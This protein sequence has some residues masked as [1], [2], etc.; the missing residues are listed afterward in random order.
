MKKPCYLIFATVALVGI[1]I[2][3]AQSEA[4]KGGVQID[5]GWRTNVLPTIKTGEDFSNDLLPTPGRC[6]SIWFVMPAGLAGAWRSE[7][8]ES[9]DTKIT[10][11]SFENEV[12]LG[13]EIDKNGTIW[14]CVKSPSVSEAKIEKG[15]TFRVSY[16]LSEMRLWPEKDPIQTTSDNI[17][18]TV[19]DGKIKQIR[20]FE[21]TS[22][23][24]LDRAGRMIV[25]ENPTDTERI[26]NTSY[27][28]ES[29]FLQDPDLEDDFKTWLK[30]TGRA[31]L[32]PKN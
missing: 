30:D 15:V 9:W 14:H 25:S 29:P 6:R 19:L 11:R 12:N 23:L 5:D 7:K 26:E 32:L 17:Q 21:S 16:L 28:K 1:F 4:L 10:S 18:L 24:G 13:S 20:R 22:I 27:F 31:D 3:P 8:K 2:P